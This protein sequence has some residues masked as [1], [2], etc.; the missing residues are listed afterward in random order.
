V[1][2]V[3]W[4]GDSR[5]AVQAFSRDA[6]Q[7]A[8]FQLAKVQDGRDP[9]DWKPMPSIGVGVREIRIRVSGGAI[10]VIYLATR[11]EGVY[12]LHAFRKKSARTPRRDLAL[13]RARFRSIR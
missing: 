7:S 11:P 8:G 4:L 6:R 1:R 5:E 2:P 3:V 9:D 10:R 12:V 13:A